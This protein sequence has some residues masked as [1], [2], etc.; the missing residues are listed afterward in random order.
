MPIFGSAHILTVGVAL[1]VEKNETPDPNPRRLSW[2]EL[3]R[4]RVGWRHKPGRGVDS[5]VPGLVETKGLTG[6]QNSDKKYKQVP[7]I[8]QPFKE[9]D[10]VNLLHGIS[11]HF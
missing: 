3:K 11:S 2:C 6:D 9:D 10:G 5:A 7:D 8:A 1:A 4:V